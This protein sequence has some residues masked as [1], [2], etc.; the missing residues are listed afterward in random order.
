M[1]GDSCPIHVEFPDDTTSA[2][3]TFFSCELGAEGAFFGAFA[4]TKEADEDVE[5]GIFVGEEGFPAAV[6]GV[7]AP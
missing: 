2:F 5:F 7:V 4:E 6:C 1:D 3:G